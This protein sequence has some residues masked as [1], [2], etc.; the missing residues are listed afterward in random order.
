MESPQPHDTDATSDERSSPKGTVFEG[1]ALRE[2]ARSIIGQPAIKDS[3]VELTQQA[4]TQANVP[5]TSDT[6]REQATEAV[7]TLT[8]GLRA[9]VDEALAA[10]TPDDWALIARELMEDAQMVANEAAAG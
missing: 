7:T 9:S 3:A 1:A 4:L 6:S 5:R 2:L 8:T 10:L